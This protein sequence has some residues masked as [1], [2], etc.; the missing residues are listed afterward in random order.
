MSK[1]LNLVTHLLDRSRYLRDVGRDHDANQLL[2]RLSRFQELPRAV[3]EETCTHLAESYLE[4]HKYRKAHRLLTAALAQ[5]PNNARHHY[6]LARTFSEADDGKTER[7]LEH[8]R[9]S[10]ELNP[11]QSDCL[12]DCGL[13]CIQVGQ[14][15][16][17]LGY[18]RRAVELSPHDPQTVENL[19]EGLEQVERFDEAQQIIQAALFRNSRDVRFR[20]LWED[21]QFQ[22]LYREQTACKTHEAWDAE[23]G[24]AVLPFIRPALKIVRH[25][26]AAQHAPHSGRRMGMS[27]RQAR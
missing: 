23:R 2:S 9:K 17:G 10:L 22:R 12:S 18:L 5:A 19:A 21:H 24:P 13:V 14:I 11:D 1:T 8:F 16:E 6:L 7:A 3:A 20:R 4:Q 15:D 26:A 25:D 27:Q